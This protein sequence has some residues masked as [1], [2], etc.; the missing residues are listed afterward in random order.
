MKSLAQTKYAGAPGF[1]EDLG[2][3]YRIVI[4]VMKIEQG[5]AAEHWT[6]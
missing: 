5:I 6:Q 2:V 1:S 4:R 3:C